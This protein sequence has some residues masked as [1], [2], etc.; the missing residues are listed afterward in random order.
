MPA[1]NYEHRIGQCK[2]M[3]NGM[4]ATV[5]KYRSATDID[6][7]F[8][9]GTIV[10]SKTWQSFCNGQ[11]A[12]PSLTFISPLISE[13]LNETRVMNNG[14]CATVIAYRSHTD[15]DVR[16]SDGAIVSGRTYAHFKKG[17]IAH[18]NDCAE[19][20]KQSRQ[21]ETRMMNNGMKAILIAYHAACNVDVEFEDGTIITNRRYDDFK[22][23]T[24]QHPEQCA[25][26]LR[27]NR[28]GEE[29]MMNC[30]LMAKIIEYRQSIDIDVQFEDGQIVKNKS[31]GRF[32]DGTIAHP[33]VSQTYMSLQEFFVAYYLNQC[34]F[35]KIQQGEWSDKGFGKLELDFYHPGTNIAIEVDGGIHSKE[36]HLERDLRKNQLCKAMGVKLYRL[37]DPTLEE[38]SDNI[39]VNYTLN[40]KRFKSGLIDCGNEL[41]EI[42]TENK[43]SFQDGFID[44]KRDYQ[45]LF[46][47]HQKECINY[48][49]KMRIGETV[50]H[51]PTNQNM[52][53][54]AYRDYHH[55]DV[56]FDDGTIVRDRIYG[57]FKKGQIGHPT[58]SSEYQKGMRIG[59]SKKMNCGQV[60]V[61]IH[62]HSA[63]DI[64]VEFEDGTVVR[65]ATYYNFT[66]ANI[67]NPSLAPSQTFTHRIGESNIMNCGK[68]ATI[69]A[70]RNQNDIDVQFEDGSIAK[71]KKYVRFKNGEI[72]YP[73]EAKSSKRIG[74]KRMMNCGM[75]ASIIA[76]RKFKDIDIQFADGTIKNHVSYKH[77][78]V[79]N[80]AH[81]NREPDHMAHNRLGET[82]IMNGCH[83]AKIIAYNSSTNI[84]V[85][86]EDGTVRRDVTYRDFKR[87]ILK[88][89]NDLHERQSESRTNESRIMK[90]G[91]RATIV[92]YRNASSI[93]VQF[94]DGVTVYNRTYDNFKHG[95]IRHPDKQ[96]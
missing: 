93:D 69:V 19:A 54:I 81:P 67:G 58:H 17:N 77:F 75:M 74:E 22:K 92:T 12:N 6:V 24:I 94:D 34:G 33:E 14:M 71:H 55:V 95:K 15:I 5:I 36:G 84:D 20:K 28:L 11:I 52:R 29:R 51:K 44:F 64:D 9:D 43:I 80:I 16:F 87:G 79:G 32:K 45:K 18:P 39:S 56:Q 49:T 89:P 91:L 65:H 4:A 86:F 83:Q 88:H 70:Y 60:A 50:F 27:I 10:K 96:S 40:G 53:I 7:R 25:A 31:Y 37:R 1:K 68:Q 59:E 13:R 66:K 72:G 76:Y 8:E 41:I 46:A 90:C 48:Y 78:K 62:Y 73:K 26:A 2:T 57:A 82:N 42:L 61:I 21:G 85:E 47:K 35:V 3:R 38:L 63:D 23:G 30:G